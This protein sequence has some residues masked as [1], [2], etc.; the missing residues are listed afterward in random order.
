MC[1]YAVIK[2]NGVIRTD[3]VGLR[4]V[5]CIGIKFEIVGDYKSGPEDICKFLNNKEDSFLK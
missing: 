5:E 1:E 2:D 3:E 4:L